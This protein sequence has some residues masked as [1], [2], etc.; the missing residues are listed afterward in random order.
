MKNN[1][2]DEQNIRQQKSIET[3]LKQ[4]YIKLEHLQCVN[5]LIVEESIKN[6]KTKR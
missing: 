6:I 4:D 3:L 5:G 1:K 2:I